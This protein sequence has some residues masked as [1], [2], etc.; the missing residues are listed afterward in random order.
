MGRIRRLAPERIIVI[1]ATVFDVVRRPL[2]DAAL[3]I[4]D[5]RVPFPGSAQQRRFDAAFARALR[6]RPIVR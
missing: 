2:I 6:R 4:V 1:K 5:M 3:R